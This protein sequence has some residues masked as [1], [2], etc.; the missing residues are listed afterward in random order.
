[1]SWDVEANQVMGLTAEKAWILFLQCR[2]SLYLL[3]I[4]RILPG[5][6]DLIGQSSSLDTASGLALFWKNQFLQPCIGSPYL[7]V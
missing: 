5:V 4:F 3:R 6:S 1:M 2:K 7:L